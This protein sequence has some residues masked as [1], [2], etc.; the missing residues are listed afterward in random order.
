ME[1][2]FNKLLDL[3]Q[4]MSFLRLLGYGAI[5][6]DDTGKFYI[7]N[8]KKK[9]VGTIRYKKLQK[10]NTKKGIQAVYGYVM[11]IDNGK[12]NCFKI[13]E[14]ME[15]NSNYVF[16]IKRKNQRIDQVNLSFGDT[17]S[18]TVLSPICGY[19]HFSISNHKLLCHFKNENENYN[20]EEKVGVEFD[21][22]MATY[23]Y[24]SKF[25]KKDDLLETNE[26]NISFAY[27]P[28]LEFPL[29]IQEKYNLNGIL[30][31]KVFYDNN[32]STLEE[33][34]KKHEF[35]I[36]TFTY[37]RYLLEKILP[38]KEDLIATFL[39]SIEEL[40]PIMALFVPDLISNQ[41]QIRRK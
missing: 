38:F 25:E 14:E 2:N 34:I 27:N 11:K 39:E 10:E 24:E 23:S 41:K 29:Y 36:N 33:A 16:E 6:P 37:L 4:E 3:E 1:Q 15:E 40:E 21:K 17:P 22:D 8:K 30:S 20:F 31:E 28:N 12:I 13:R 35:G 26:C 18:V 32:K 19:I 9:P 5:G 7:V